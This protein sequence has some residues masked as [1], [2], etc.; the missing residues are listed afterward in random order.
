M[1]QLAAQR[2]SHVRRQFTVTGAL[3]HLGEHVLLDAERHLRHRVYRL[4]GLEPVVPAEAE[5]TK[6][7]EHVPPWEPPFI[8]DVEL[9]LEGEADID[10]DDIDFEGWLDESGR[11]PK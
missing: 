3:A 11:D 7:Y 5:E 1:L 4:P 2:I 10:P 6:G 9:D 8:V